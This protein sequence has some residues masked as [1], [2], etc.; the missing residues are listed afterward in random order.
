M[1][2]RA[3]AGDLGLGLELRPVAAGG[4][5]LDAHLA[6]AP[7]RLGQRGEVL[8]RGAAG[9]GQHVGARQAEGGAGRPRVGLGPERLAHPAGHDRGSTPSRSRSS[10]RENSET[11]TT[12]R[13]RRAMRGSSARCQ[14]T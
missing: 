12:S 2:D 7:R 1:A 9:H 10:S 3:H 5:E 8:A 14:A 13:A 4:D 11:V 6:Q